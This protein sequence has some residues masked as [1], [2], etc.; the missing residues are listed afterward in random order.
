MTLL[1]RLDLT[2]S[3]S[4]NVFLSTRVEVDK[5]V[6]AR[7]WPASRMKSVVGPGFWARVEKF[8]SGFEGKAERMMAGSADRPQV[9]LTMGDVTGIGP[10]VIV[11]AWLDPALHALAR[12][13]VIGDPGVLGRARGIVAGADGLNVQVV[14]APEEAEP[15]LNTIP[16]LTVHGRFGDLAGL[17]PG[18]IDG[19][20]GRAA[21]EFLTTAIDLALAH[22]IDAIVTLPL[23]KH[24]LH[25][26]GIE[27]PG[28]TEILAERCSA[29]DHAMMLYLEGQSQQPEPGRRLAP[30]LGVVHVTLHV[31]LRRV[32]DLLGCESIL[33]KIRLADRAMRPMTEGMQPRIAVSSLNPHAGEDG[34]FGDEERTLIRPAVEAA[35]RE[36]LDAAGPLPND[37]LFYHA[38]NGAYDA[39]VAM[40]HD[41]GH[42]ALK[43]VG[44]QRA[45]N[46]TLGLP[47]VRTSVAHGTAFDIAWQGLADPSSLIAAVRVAGRLVS[48]R[49]R[50]TG[51]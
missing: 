18:V 27:H 31:A 25:L 44:F 51:G 40:Y 38:L 8:S 13:V 42:I 24:A 5:A 46:V 48:G 47:I 35:R 7:S 17:A 3:N 26:A 4:A 43:T 23:N 16:C 45:V 37:T 9:S 15:A 22:R 30:G 34:L 11:R 12:P 29:P 41:Q 10:E 28:H 1:Y 33:S 36:G 50:I 49:R 14:A 6:F 21:Y 39:V 2:L 32:F 20:A 19:R